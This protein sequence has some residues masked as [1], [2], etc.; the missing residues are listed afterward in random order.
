MSDDEDLTSPASG[1]KGR[2]LPIQ[3]PYLSWRDL[4]VGV[5]PLVILTVIAFIVALR[6]VSPAPP[7]KLTMVTGPADSTFERVG[8]RYKKI[9]AREGITLTLLQSEGSVDN[10][11]R[12][13]DPRSKVDIGL[14]Q[15]GLTTTDT[16]DLVS[17]GSISQWVRRGAACGLSRSRC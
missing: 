10:L 7:H 4:A 5:W 6:F 9:L 8:E 15:A 11:N 16:S 1:P 3:I 13:A 17:L 2:R 12:L 14:V